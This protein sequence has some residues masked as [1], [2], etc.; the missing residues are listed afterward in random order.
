MPT[1]RRGFL[2]AALAA[3]A[4]TVSRPFAARG[5]T[6]PTPAPAPAASP[7]P[8]PPDPKAEALAK[9]ARE[10]YGKFLSPDELT[11]LDER[12]AAIERRSQRLRAVRL[13]NSD[14]PVAEFR[15]GRL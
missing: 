4:A 12:C 14:E 9:L 8:A 6:T 10:R 1:S 5:Q 2:G 15:A 3:A 13:T 11:L 7:T